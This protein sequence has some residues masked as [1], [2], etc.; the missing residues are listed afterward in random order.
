MP[1][2]ICSTPTIPIK[3]GHNVQS[4]YLRAGQN[5]KATL[6]NTIDFTKG[7]VLHVVREGR[8]LTLALSNTPSSVT[9]VL[10]AYFPSDIGPEARQ[11]A[12]LEFE[13]FMEATLSTLRDSEEAIYG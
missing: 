6:E 10:R 3:S 4:S 8:P 13:E 1:S 5:N 12:S 2:E 9:Q 7:G 11:A